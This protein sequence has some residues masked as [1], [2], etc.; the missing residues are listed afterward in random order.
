MRDEAAGR[1]LEDEGAVHLLVEVELEGVE[2]LADVA[3]AGLLEAPLEES[4]LAFEQLVLDE[5][6]QE[7]DRGQPLRLS[8]EEPAFETGRHA[9]AAKLAEGA[10]EFDERHVGTSWV[11]CAI[12]AR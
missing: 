6:R 8:L 2:R 4:V 3:E 5:G 1:E 9:R 10:L 11:F 12:T 7:V